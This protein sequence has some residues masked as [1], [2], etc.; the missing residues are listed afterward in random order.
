MIVDL[1]TYLFCIDRE[2]LLPPMF[3]LL[4]GYKLVLYILGWQFLILVLSVMASILFQLPFNLDIYL[5]SSIKLIILLIWYC[6][7]C[8]LAHIFNCSGLLQKF[9]EILFWFECLGT[10]FIVCMPVLLGQTAI[11]ISIITFHLPYFIP[12]D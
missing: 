3:L 4:S 6:M 11:L 8:Y 1:V 12:E 2:D 5:Y 7:H 10:F 9:F